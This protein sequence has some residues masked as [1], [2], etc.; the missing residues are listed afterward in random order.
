MKFRSAWLMVLLACVPLNSQTQKKVEITAEPSHHRVLQNA[1]LRVFNMNIGPHGASKLYWH[2]HDYVFITLGAADVSNEVEGK[3]PVTLRLKDGDTR[4][5]AGNFAHVTKSTSDKPFHNI[6]VEFLKDAHGRKS[7]PPPWDEERGLQVLH[8][9]TLDILFVKDGVRVSEIQLQPGG[10]IP[11][12]RHVG[13]HLLVA[14]SNLQ[15]RSDVIGKAPSIRRMSP[16]EVAWIAEK[17]SHTVTN[18][19]TGPAKFITLEF[20]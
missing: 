10:M 20:Q 18:A 11:E 14:V 4:F 12:H 3:P 15:L 2:R 1:Y 13:P 6:T 5:V 9:G 8:G 17:L 7:P 16:G 19:G